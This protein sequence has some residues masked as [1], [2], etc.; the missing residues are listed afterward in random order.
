MLFLTRRKGEVII[1]TDKVSGQT[2]GTILVD[3]IGI[4]DISIGIDAPPTIQI[5]R[6]FYHGNKRIESQCNGEHKHGNSNQ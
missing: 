3:A 2:I 4:T 1:L 5:D 6:D